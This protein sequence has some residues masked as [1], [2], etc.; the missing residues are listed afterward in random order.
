MKIAKDARENL[1]VNFEINHVN[2]LYFKTIFPFVF[3]NLTWPL[4][5]DG[6]QGMKHAWESNP[7]TKKQGQGRL[8]HLHTFG[9]HYNKPLQ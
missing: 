2:N 1:C 3:E 4:C 7:K 8:L 6:D 9:Y 5:W